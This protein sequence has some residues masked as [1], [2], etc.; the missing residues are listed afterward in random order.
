MKKC[1]Y[2]FFALLT[3][4][5]GC[6]QSSSAEEVR[7][8]IISAEQGATM[9]ATANPDGMK[10]AA[11][12]QGTRVKLIREEASWAKV[13][14]NGRLGWV[15]NEFIKPFTEDL[16]PI[17]SSYYKLLEETDDVIYALV[18]DFTQDGIEDLFVI[19]D[20]NP[21]KGQYIEKIY[22]GGTV[23]YQKN[24][25]HGLSVLKDATDYYL[26]HHTQTN[27]E[28][29]YKLS[30]L[31][32]QAKTDYYEASEGKNSYEVTANT[33]LNTYFIVQSGNGELSELTLTHEQAASKDYYGGV[34][35][36][37]YDE[38]IYL[39]NYYLS[40]GGKTEPLLEKDYNALFAKYEKAK[41]AKIIYS[42][43]Y[44]SASLSDKFSFDLK[45]AKNELLDL[46]AAI[47]PEKEIEV[48]PAEMDSLKIKLA[49]SVFLEMPYEN[50]VSRN[51]YT[52]VKN[53]EDGVKRG[54]PGYEASYFTK[55]NSVEI[56]IDGMQY[57]DSTPMENV[58]NDFYGTTI[59]ADEFN[60]L[61]SVEGRA[62][63]D[64]VYQFP[65]EE[66]EAS[67]TYIYRQLLS[68]EQLQNGYDILQ[69][70]DYNMPMEIVVSPSNENGLIAG[71][72]VQ[73]GYVV[74][75]RL[76]FKTGTKWV[77]IDTVS[78]IDLMDSKHYQT[79][80]N[81][82]PLMQRYIAEQQIAEEMKPDEDA[83]PIVA[84]A[85]TGEGSV[86]A[87]DQETAV[88][89]GFMALVLALVIGAF[90]GA[91]FIYYRKTKQK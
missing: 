41:G 57:M 35:K 52:M 23:I 79:Y 26:F 77:Y 69:F 85:A 19:V 49:Q 33:Y 82:L 88:S 51:A 63:N 78:Q 83:E 40:N 5:L 58:I 6:M 44:K 14:Y 73:K 66:E 29:K 8:S 13:E 45:R 59:N 54:L 39:E 36:N 32:E 46:A 3:G 80:E 64:G 25:K 20:S 31:N 37:G 12:K 68:M 27:S 1:F 15:R 70:A 90:G 18:N 43:D 62:L 22:S 56:P 42:D 71:E 89:W 53:V 47:A 67:E 4:F 72:Q 84:S 61:A 55:E 16:L 7:H 65:I 81:T 74:F 48:L 38:T 2:I 21:S 10:V 76:P 24:L 11:L 87:A 50:G 60:A 34:K 17:Y 75:K 30:A 86:Q 28:K 91:Y 9:T